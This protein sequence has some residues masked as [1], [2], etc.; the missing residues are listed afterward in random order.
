MRLHDFT[1]AI[2]R[3]P[4]TSVVHGLRAHDGPGPTFEGVAREHAA[5]ARA[6]ERAGVSVEILA[7][8]EEFPDSIF[9]EDPALVFGEGAIL[10]NPGT[11]TRMEEARLL[12]PALEA[13]FASLQP[14]DRGHADGGDV[15]VTPDLVMIGLSARTDRVGAEALARALGHLGRPAQIVEPPKG[16]LHLKTIASLIDEDTILT[17]AAGEASG[18]FS[19]FRQVVLDPAEEPAA[20]ALRVNDTLLLP[21]HHPRIAER[22]DALGF[23][24]VLLDTT[25]I[26]RI[27]AGL[28]CM[29][30][31][32]RAVLPGSGRDK[33]KTQPLPHPNVPARPSVR[34]GPAS[35]DIRQD[36]PPFRSTRRRSILRS[37]ASPSPPIRAARRDSR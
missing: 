28:S 32:W 16:A 4:A 3:A 12:R 26:G 24:L 15:L 31:R 2:L 35:P 8:L 19:R 7:P 13:R 9:V 29:S 18:L 34:V 6:L 30:L 20:N 36:A 10:L 23:D 1:H 33:S 14:L 17:T 37:C 11:A 5:Y 27:D 25:H 21:A 22:L